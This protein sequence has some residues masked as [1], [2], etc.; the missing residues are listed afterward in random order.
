[1]S[2]FQDTAMVYDTVGATIQTIERLA[3]EAVAAVAKGRV[4]MCLQL[5]A[6]DAAITIYGKNR[7]PNIEYGPTTGKANLTI[8]M[9]ADL[10]HEILLQRQSIGDAFKAGHV[11]IKGPIFKLMTMGKIIEAGQ[12]YYPDILTEKGYV[13]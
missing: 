10:F 7:P 5:T 6:P 4:N 12:K 13:V 11:K 8:T 3:P 2:F 9:S 1:M